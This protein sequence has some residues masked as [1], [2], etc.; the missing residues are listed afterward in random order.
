MN[1]RTFI[2]S[3]ALGILLALPLAFL[4]APLAPAL[5]QVDTSWNQGSTRKLLD[6]LIKAPV[7]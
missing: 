7:R 3:L 2:G 1:P 4:I 6:Y 5:G